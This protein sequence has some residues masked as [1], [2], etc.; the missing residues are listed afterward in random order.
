MTTYFR[1]NTVRARGDCLSAEGTLTMN[2]ELSAE[3]H[4]RVAA[5]L[6]A[7]AATATTTPLKERLIQQAKKHDVARGETDQTATAPRSV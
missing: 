3:F 4:R 2:L 5:R 1:E 7:V 6:R